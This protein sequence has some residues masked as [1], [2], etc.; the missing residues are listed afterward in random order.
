MDEAAL[1]LHGSPPEVASRVRHGGFLCNAELFEHGFFSISAAE[2]LAMDP[3][4]R[5]LLECGYGSFHAAGM[6]KASLLG[7]I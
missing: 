6:S 4:Q 2:A 1:D 5:Q 7:G 3:Q